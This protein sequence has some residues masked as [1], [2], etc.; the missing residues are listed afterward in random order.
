MQQDKYERK[1]QS[2]NESLMCLIAVQWGVG[3]MKWYAPMSEAMLSN[4]GLENVV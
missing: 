4:K 2:K 3:R 1:Q